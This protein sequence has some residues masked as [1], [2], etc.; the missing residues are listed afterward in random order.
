M[1]ISSPKWDSIKNNSKDFYVI[2]EDINMSLFKVAASA[3]DVCRDKGRKSAQ[4]RGVLQKC[5]GYGGG[6]GF[7]S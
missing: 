6:F 3:D 5:E 1:I 2:C 7:V 4:G